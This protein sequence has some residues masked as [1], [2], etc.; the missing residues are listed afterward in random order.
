[1]KSAFAHFEQRLRMIN[2]VIKPGYAELRLTVLSPGAGAAGQ[3]PDLAVRR[4]G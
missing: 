3:R 1:M 4:L 2:E